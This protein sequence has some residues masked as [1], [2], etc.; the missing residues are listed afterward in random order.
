M[1]MDREFNGKCTRPPW[2][3]GDGSN[4]NR[5]TKTYKTDGTGFGTTCAGIPAKWHQRGI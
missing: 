3:E 5:F 2:D 4:L 1:E